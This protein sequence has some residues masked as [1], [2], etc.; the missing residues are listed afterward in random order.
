MNNI[1][2]F[3]KDINFIWQMNETES[4]VYT[5]MCCFA[6]SNL[7]IKKEVFDKYGSIDFE[8]TNFKM[9]NL[10]NPED[11]EH[12]YALISFNPKFA[13]H[14]LHLAFDNLLEIGDFLYYFRK[15]F[16]EE[17]LKTIIKKCG[18]FIEEDYN[19]HLQVKTD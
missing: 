1:K 11:D 4:D 15:L 10:L 16:E 3:E 6:N 13:K 7:L 19:F 8:T 12:F 17:E 18:G 2:N 9:K 5:V 14:H